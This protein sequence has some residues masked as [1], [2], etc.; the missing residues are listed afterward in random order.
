MA[1]AAVTAT[2]GRSRQKNWRR[3][4]AV[5]VIALELDLAADPVMRRQVEQ[6]FNAAFKLHRALQRDAESLCTAYLAA[7]H[8]RKASGPKAVR[9]R[10]GLD[11]NGIEGRA[12]AHIERAGW[13]RAHLTKATGLH[14]AVP[15]NPATATT[16]IRG[17]NGG[18]GGQAPPRA[19]H[20][21]LAGL[22][23]NSL[24]AGTKRR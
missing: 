14:I 24:S 22:G 16:A 15:P 23:I 18:K 11:R 21:P 7:R 1:P 9:A 20:K 3:P 12:K 2:R 10:L 19:I 4:E 8:E 17:D 5:S 6:H 13:M